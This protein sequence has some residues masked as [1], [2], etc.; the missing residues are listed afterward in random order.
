MRHGTSDVAKLDGE[1]GLLHRNLEVAG[2]ST[3]VG[4]KFKAI[5]SCS[6]Y[7]QK[8]SITFYNVM[9]KLTK[10]NFQ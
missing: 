3:V 4:C 9:L 7:S 1:I 8:G 6:Y 2:V 5:G 10:V